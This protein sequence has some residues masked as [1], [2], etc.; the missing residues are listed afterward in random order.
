[1]RNAIV[2]FAFGSL[3]GAAAHGQAL[4]AT[5]GAGDSGGGG[6]SDGSNGG[7]ITIDADG[8]DGEQATNGTVELADGVAVNASAGG[9]GGT[10]G[11]AGTIVVD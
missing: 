8:D 3:L 6:G 1:M 10:A 9:V 5:G 2:V 4:L 11:A 7:R